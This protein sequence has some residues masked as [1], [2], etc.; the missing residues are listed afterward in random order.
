MTEGGN[1]DPELLLQNAHAA[2]EQAREPRSCEVYSP[3]PQA[4][5]RRRLL[6]DVWGMRHVGEIRTRTVDMHIVK[7]RKKIAADG[8]AAIETVRGEGYRFSG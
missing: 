8:G 1:V 7:L 4:R 3:V 2:A 5:S 6:I